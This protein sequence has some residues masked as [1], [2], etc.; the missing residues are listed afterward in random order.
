MFKEATSRIKEIIFD[1][2][3]RLKIHFKE[4]TSTESI[5]SFIKN[6]TISIKNNRGEE[7]FKK[8][9]VYIYRRIKE[10]VLLNINREVPVRNKD[11]RIEK[12]QVKPGDFAYFY[13]K[14]TL[15]EKRFLIKAKSQERR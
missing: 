6:I 3:C 11:P 13:C 9:L 10:S 5:D 12:F 1:N 14:S 2:N 15:L 4:N 7:L 8:E